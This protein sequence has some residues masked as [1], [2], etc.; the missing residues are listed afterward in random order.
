MAERVEAQDRMS[1]LQK[2]LSDTDL[3][4]VLRGEGGGVVWGVGCGCGWGEEWG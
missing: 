4:D 2:A 1:T 3:L